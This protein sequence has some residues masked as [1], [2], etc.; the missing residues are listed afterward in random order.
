MRD[1]MVATN[2]VIVFTNSTVVRDMG[3]PELTVR[4]SKRPACAKCQIIPG[5]AEPTVPWKGKVYDVDCFKKVVYAEKAAG[6]L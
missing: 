6:R 1:M 4:Q 3:G 5:I 2:E